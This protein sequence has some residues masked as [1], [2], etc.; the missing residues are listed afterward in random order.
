MPR[1]VRGGGIFEENDGGDGLQISE[2]FGIFSVRIP[3]VSFADSVPNPFDPSGHFT[4]IGGIG[5]LSPRG[6]AGAPAP[7]WLHENAKLCVDRK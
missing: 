3:S 5:P 2:C 6:A 1:M 4:L 7:E